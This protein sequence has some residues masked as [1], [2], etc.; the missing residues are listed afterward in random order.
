MRLILTTIIL[1]MLAPPVWASPGI[2]YDFD[3]PQL[4]NQNEC[5]KALEL[6]TVFLEEKPFRYVVFGGQ[7]YRILPIADFFGLTVICEIGKVK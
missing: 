6:G 1:T 5:L 7:M 4:I 3:T 2:K